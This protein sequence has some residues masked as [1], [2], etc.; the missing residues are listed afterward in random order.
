MPL[1]PR[2]VISGNS[3][4]AMQ[5]GASL[6]N[7]VVAGRAE[8]QA[9]REFLLQAA[10]DRAFFELMHLRASEVDSGNQ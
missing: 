7:G 2:G 5:P 9:Q 6:T 3:R 1:S 8:M 4:D 10:R